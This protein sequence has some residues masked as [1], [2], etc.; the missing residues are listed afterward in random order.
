MQSSIQCVCVGGGGGGGDSSPK[1]SS[2]PPPPSPLKYLYAT[3]VEC[4]LRTYMH[5]SPLPLPPL[6][7]HTHISPHTV[8][9][10]APAS[11][12]G[13][14]LTSTLIT[15]QWSPIPD[16]HVNG[17][18]LF[19]LVDVTEVITNTTLTFHAVRTSIN[20][21]PLHPYYRYR[22]QVTGFTVGVG[23]YTSFFYVYTGEACKCVM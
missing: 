14:P 21:G 9:T 20:V 2:F 18:I 22:C 3:L 10:A 17:I 1:R 12:S 7:T 11:P 19:Y 13:F 4:T 5:A 8:P 23:P 15:I 16:E 6:H